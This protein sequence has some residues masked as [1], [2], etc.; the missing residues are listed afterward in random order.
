MDDPAI[1]TKI[2]L[3]LELIDKKTNRTV[4]DHPFEREEPA[5]G[6]N[7]KDVVGSMDRNLQ[8]LASEAAAEIDKFLASRH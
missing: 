4:W 6:K 5:N 8:Q 1:Q 7:I 2:S 3:Q